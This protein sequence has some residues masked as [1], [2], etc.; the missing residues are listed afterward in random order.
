MKIS[1][2]S[3]ITN[4]SVRMIRYYEEKGLL[5]PQ[6]TTSGY[7][8]FTEKDVEIVQKIKLFK[9]VGFTL[10]DIQPVMECQFNSSQNGKIC[11]KLKEK[12]LSKINQIEHSIDGLTQ[13]KVTLAQY[14]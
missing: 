13:A 6:R 12:I 11:D 4:V 8:H 9:E 1:E 3:K 10:E 2:L 7:R 5:T 14:V